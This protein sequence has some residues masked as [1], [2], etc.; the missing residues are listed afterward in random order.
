MTVDGTG[1]GCA[2]PEDLVELCGKGT[3][4]TRRVF[5]TTSRQWKEAAPR[6]R[7]PMIVSV[8]VIHDLC[9][10]AKESIR[11]SELRRPATTEDMAKDCTTRGDSTRCRR[12]SGRSGRRVQAPLILPRT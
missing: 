4:E 7:A 9:E 3:D 5:R 10:R 6:R 2:R 8:D 1:S 12:K 11:A